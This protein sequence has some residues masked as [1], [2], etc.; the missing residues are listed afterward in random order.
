MIKT[1]ILDNDEN[2]IVGIKKYIE[3]NMKGFKIEKT[4]NKPN[5]FFDYIKNENPDLIILELNFIYNIKQFLHDFNNI[6]IILYGNY[7]NSQIMK[8]LSN[9]DSII[10]YIIR[11]VKP[12][13]LK[14]AL[15]LFCEHLKQKQIYEIES[16]QNL[17]NYKEYLQVFE[18]KFLTFLINEHDLT[19]TEIFENFNYFNIQINLPFRVCVI[20]IDY[21]KDVLLKCSKE[22][23][24]LT[25]FKMLN[26]IKN[27]IKSGLVFINLFNEIVF[28][29]DNLESVDEV[30]VLLKNIKT[31]IFTELSLNVSIGVGK[32][33]H[34]YTFIKNSFNEAIRALIYR[35]IIGYNSIIFIEQMEKQPQLVFDYDYINGRE[36]FLANIAIIGEKD[37][38]IKILDEIFKK[39]KL[40]KSIYEPIISQ[41][42]ISILIKITKNLYEQNINFKEISQFFD[43]NKIISLKTIESAYVVLKNGLIDFCIYI[44]NLKND[45]ENNLFQNIFEYINKN[46]FENVNYIIISQKFLCNQEYV[47]K[48]FEEKTQQNIFDYIS[49]I[50]INKAKE[51]ILTTNLTDDIIA[52]KIGYNDVNLFRNAF[53]KLEGCLVGDFR[54][55]NKDKK[56]DF[57][58]FRKD[59]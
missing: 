36:I 3:N 24:Y 53:K 25:I 58:N 59:I 16:E 33:Y 5:K 4:F 31:K 23:K 19:E 18:N 9:F 6:K 56:N 42:V 45:E 49:K 47:K 43:I 21:F 39:L 35:Y 55:I 48:I 30:L 29:V 20:R 13:C 12:S 46:Y 10:T 26:I 37:Y 40:Y 28:I 27:N 2:N 22:Q 15:N 1:I 8:N 51:L 7:E 57:S 44:K 52:K 34:K 54:F 50:R 17:N 38:C 11:P 14:S 41:I 32:L